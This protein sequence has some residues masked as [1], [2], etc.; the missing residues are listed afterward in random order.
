MSAL[1]LRRILLVLATV[2]MGL[3]ASTALAQRYGHGIHSAHRISSS[4]YGGHY[5]HRHL[6]H[7]VSVSIGGYPYGYGIGYGYGYRGL[8]YRGFGGYGLGGY[9]YSSFGYPYSGYVSAYRGYSPYYSSRV[10]GLNYYARPAYVYVPTDTYRSGYR[11]GVAQSSYTVP[12]DPTETLQQPSADAASSDANSQLP[13]DL[14]PG[15]VLPDGAR[16]IS[17]DPIGGN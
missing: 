8:S 1:G 16:V 10:V 2:S 13:A 15:M 17:V 4:Y 9:G 3:A 12:S 11:Y 7:G 5:G 6:G 14:R